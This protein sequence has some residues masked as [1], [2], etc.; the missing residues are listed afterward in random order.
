ME[1]VNRRRQPAIDGDT[2]ERIRA[3]PALRVLPGGIPVQQIEAA[4]QGYERTRVAYQVLADRNSQQFEDYE[5]LA[6]DPESTN[7]QRKG[8]V[9][10]RE[11]LAATFAQ[12]E[13]ALGNVSNALKNVA[14]RGQSGSAAVTELN[15]M[16]NLQVPHMRELGSQ[17]ENSQAAFSSLEERLSAMHTPRFAID[18]QV[19]QRLLISV[20]VP[21]LPSAQQW[22]DQTRGRLPLGD[23]KFKAI[24]ADLQDY[25]KCRGEYEQTAAQNTKSF[26]RFEG[27]LEY[28]PPTERYQDYKTALKQ[29]LDATEASLR[30][31]SDKLNEL[32]E[33]KGSRQPAVDDLRQRV[34]RADAAI[35]MANTV[36]AQAAGLLETIGAESQ[37]RAPPA[38]L[39]ARD[40]PVQAGQ[41][42]AV[43]PPDLN[44][45]LPERPATLRPDSEILPR[46][47]IIPIGLASDAQPREARARGRR[48]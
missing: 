22:R 12:A 46:D 11:K 18:A 23:K 15:Q 17:L 37:N 39:K 30:G 8:Y 19:R 25:A 36:F 13:L 5:R 26:S 32:G 41:R 20:D 16:M 38:L 7:Y 48:R 45:P 3:I 42:T 35:K 33:V 43:R 34:R 21:E 27:E 10:F 4:V 14:V 9:E 29:R 31:L 28:G 6:R 2:E 40:A 44:K 47:E 24:E 1:D